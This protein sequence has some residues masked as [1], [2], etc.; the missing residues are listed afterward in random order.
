VVAVPSAV[1]TMREANGGRKI[2]HQV[3]FAARVMVRDGV[4]VC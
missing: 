2:S 3:P 4:L 1:V